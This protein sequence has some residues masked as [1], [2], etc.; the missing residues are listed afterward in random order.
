MKPKLLNE[1]IN[2]FLPQVKS[3]S[4]GK[5]DGDDY[6]SPCQFSGCGIND[7]AV[8]QVDLLRSSSECVHHHSI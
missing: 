8:G 6:S 1:I 2:K 3:K 5:D 7:S 4:Y